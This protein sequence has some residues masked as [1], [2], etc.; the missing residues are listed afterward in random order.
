MSDGRT[1]A[2]VAT[3]VLIIGSATAVYAA[4]KVPTMRPFVVPFSLGLINGLLVT[5]DI[6]M[7]QG[8]THEE[9]RWRRIPIIG[10][11]AFMI[12]ATFWYP[13]SLAVPHRGISHVLIIGTL[14]RFFYQF[15][16]A[17]FWLATITAWWYSRSPREFLSPYIADLEML[18]AF[19]LPFLVGWVIQDIGHLIYD[20]R[21]GDKRK[22]KRNKRS[23]RR[24]I[25]IMSVVCMVIF[26]IWRQLN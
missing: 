26:Y 2:R 6:D 13:Y 20:G 16:G 3:T 14:T 15:A 1:H 9:A 7:D 18:A 12:F 11:L 4:A 19:S 8:I 21:F 10:F 22:R 23:G 17:F 5:P 25:F 24:T